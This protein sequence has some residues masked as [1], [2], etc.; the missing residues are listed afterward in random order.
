MIDQNW[1][2]FLYNLANQVLPGQNVGQVPSSEADQID[3]VDLDAAGSDLTVAQRKIDNTQAL[4]QA[5]ADVSDVAKLEHALGSL[6][7]SQGMQP[8]YADGADVAMLAQQIR[9]LAEQAP[10][11]EIGASLLQLANALIL[12]TD[13][14]L[15]DPPPPAGPVIPIAPG[16]SPFT[17]TAIHDGTICISGPPTAVINVIRYGT[18]VPT[19]MTDGTIPMRKN[20]QVSITWSGGTAPVMNYLPN[21]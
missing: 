13:G 2:L 4:E 21:K 20:D 18:T 11:E 14:L 1:Y 7:V 6:Q 17:Y 3:M 15:Q 16:A 9:S 12:A 10:T 5:W 19:G 8:E